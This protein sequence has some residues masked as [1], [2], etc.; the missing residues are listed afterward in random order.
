[1]NKSEININSF[2]RSYW[3]YFLELE[4]Q[5]YNTRRYV[6]FDKSN[7]KAHSLEYLQL[8]QAVCGEIDVIAKIIAEYTDNSFASLDNKNI[9]K[10]G[11][12]IQQAFPDIEN[13]RVVFNKTYTL[14]PWKKFWYTKYRDNKGHVRFK[15]AEKKETPKWW[16]AYIKIKHERTSTY[17][18]NQTNYNR[19]NLENLIDSMAALYYLEMMFLG[20]LKADNNDTGDIEKSK[21]FYIE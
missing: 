14:T 13:T 9:Q 10:W 6:D 21:L 5:L 12:Y 19:A 4:E 18:D 17:N 2:I 15:L 1:M 16:L 8:I 3:N 20:L 7:F 11:Y